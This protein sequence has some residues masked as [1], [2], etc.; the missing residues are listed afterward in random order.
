MNELIIVIWIWINGLNEYKWMNGLY[1]Y[2][3]MNGLYEW[4]SMN[5]LHESKWLFF[6]WIWLNVF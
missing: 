6:I 5:E 4:K 3:W 2:K 1:E